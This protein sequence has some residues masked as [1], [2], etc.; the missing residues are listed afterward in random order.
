MDRR[1]CFPP[2]EDGRMA[3]SSEENRQTFR[4]IATLGAALIESP[5]TPAKAPAVTKTLRLGAH[6][7][8]E[9]ELRR[10]QVELVKFQ[11][12]VRH[13]GVRVVV[14]FEGRDAAGKGGKIKRTTES[15]NPRIC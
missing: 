3:K 6:V 10:L 14:I 12:W 13:K 5:A 9:K 2:V 4:D 15:L 7:D 8:Y 1:V 11:Q